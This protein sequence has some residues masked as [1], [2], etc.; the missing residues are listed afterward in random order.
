MWRYIGSGADLDVRLA[1]KCRVRT[2]WWRVPYLRPA[3]LFLTFMNA[4]TPRIAANRAGAHHLNSVHG[5]YL[6]DGLRSHGMSLCRSR[7]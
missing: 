2:P 1:Y 5:I 3:D 6:R 7:R 4:E